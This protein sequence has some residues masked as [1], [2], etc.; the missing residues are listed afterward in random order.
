[1]KNRI[2]LLLMLLLSA[3]LFQCTTTG[4][5]VNASLDKYVKKF[6]HTLAKID[7]DQS[8]EM[9]KVTQKVLANPMNLTIVAH[10][11]SLGKRPDLLNL[12]KQAYKI[13][14]NDFKLSNIETRVY[15]VSQY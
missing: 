6:N 13:M 1:M 4:T 3:Y 5:N 2:L 9:I 8:E 11:L 15:P 14:A 10:I 12:Q 7:F